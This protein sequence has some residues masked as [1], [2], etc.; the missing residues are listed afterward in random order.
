[1]RTRDMT[2]GRPLR[3]ILAVALPLMLGSAFQQLYAV[4]DAAV[5][6]R[7]IGLSALAALGSADWFNWLW[8]SLAQGL[9]QGFAIPIAQAFGARDGDEVRIVGYSFDFESALTHEDM[10]AELED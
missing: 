3:L 10:F 2:E 8:W 4:V 9:A 1:M 7:G 6:G 5:V